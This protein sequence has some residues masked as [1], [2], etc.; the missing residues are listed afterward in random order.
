MDRLFENIRIPVIINLKTGIPVRIFKNIGILEENKANIENFPPTPLINVFSE[1]SV[2][3][4]PAGSFFKWEEAEGWGQGWKVFLKRCGLD[5]SLAVYEK[6]GGLE[7]SDP[8]FL[9][10]MYDKILKRKNVGVREKFP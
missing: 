7:I 3:I 10:Y 2:I 1:N 5:Q 8:L 6:K 9:L 4:V